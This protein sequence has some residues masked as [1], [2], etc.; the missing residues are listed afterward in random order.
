MNTEAF[1]CSKLPSPYGKQTCKQ[2]ARRHYLQGL[3]ISRCLNI[4]LLA[5]PELVPSGKEPLEP[6]PFQILGSEPFLTG[7]EASVPSSCSIIQFISS[8]PSLGTNKINSKD[9]FS[10]RRKIHHSSLTYIIIFRPSRA[11]FLPLILVSPAQ[12]PIENALPSSACAHAM[13]NTRFTVTKLGYVPRPYYS[14]VRE[15]TNSFTSTYNANPIH[16]KYFSAGWSLH[17]IH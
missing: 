14:A 6:D 8:C 12:S 15:I 16:Q 4:K 7:L 10:G 11:Y 2:T 17:Q 5:G 13:D 1:V 9:N 3:M